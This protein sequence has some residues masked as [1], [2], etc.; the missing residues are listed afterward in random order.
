MVQPRLSQVIISFY[1]GHKRSWHVGQNENL[2]LDMEQLF[3]IFTVEYV[4]KT[5]N[6]IA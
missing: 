3:L 4:S 6:I 1:L 5:I 2:R